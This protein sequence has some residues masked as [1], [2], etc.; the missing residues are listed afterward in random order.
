MMGEKD[1]LVFAMYLVQIINPFHKIISNDMSSC[2]IFVSLYVALANCCQ[3]P[4]VGG[5]G[6][7]TGNLGPYDMKNILVK[8]FV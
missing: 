2:P 3:W 8:R 7:A 1:G 6:N 5:F 4:Y